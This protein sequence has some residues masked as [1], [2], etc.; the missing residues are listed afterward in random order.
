MNRYKSKTDI[1]GANIRHHICERGYGY[2]FLSNDLINTYGPS[3]MEAM[4]QELAW[5]AQKQLIHKKEYKSTSSLKKLN[6]E[7]T[8]QDVTKLCDLYDAGL[9]MADI[10][11]R[12]ER[13]TS[14][15]DSK[16][17]QLRAHRRKLH[18]LSI[19][20]WILYLRVVRGEITL[21]EAIRP[22][23]KATI[24]A[25][26]TNVSRMR[27]IYGHKYTYIK[28]LLGEISLSDL[29]EHISAPLNAHHA[30]LF[31]VKEDMSR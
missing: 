31:T 18:I 30:I 11:V 10:A 5:I 3:R 16:L 21:D 8:E 9:S 12:I 15:V 7:W 19:A 25:H 28:C 17:S 29:R 2:I 23:R 1:A 20:D 27:Q 14:S 26:E 22:M 13:S 6:S 4:N 24:T